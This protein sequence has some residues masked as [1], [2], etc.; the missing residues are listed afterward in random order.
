MA[1]AP[2]CYRSIPYT[3]VLEVVEPFYY[4]LASLTAPT[5]ITP[6]MVA[7]T[8]R[9]PPRQVKIMAKKKEEMSPLRVSGVSLFHHLHI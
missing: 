7:M 5:T 9:Q 4:W 1:A 6:T 8:A 2:N 3:F